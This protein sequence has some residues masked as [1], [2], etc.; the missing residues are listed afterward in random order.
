MLEEPVLVNF[1]RLG[2]PGWTPVHPIEMQVIWEGVLEMFETY[3][4]AAIE[5]MTRKI[6][7]R[8]MCYAFGNRPMDEDWITNALMV[9][10]IRG[11][12]GKEIPELI[13]FRD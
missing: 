5:I 6:E 4:P 7:A 8:L 13:F 12:Q 11:W 3:T 1:G 2:F 9:T 10:A